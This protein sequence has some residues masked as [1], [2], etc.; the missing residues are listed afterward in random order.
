MSTTTSHA[1]SPVL[2]HHQ[3]Q[4][5]QQLQPTEQ[6]LFSLDFL[7]LAG[8]DS[9]MN[10]GSSHSAGLDMASPQ[11]LSGQQPT[12]SSD[13]GTNSSSHWDGSG[14]TNAIAG[15]SSHASS[16]TAT[17]NTSTD[18]EMGFGTQ[19][20]DGTSVTASA[21]R[22]RQKGSAIERRDSN[23]MEV[24][25]TGL[26]YLSGLPDGHGMLGMGLNGDGIGVGSG[27]GSGNGHD[28]DSLQAALLQQ[29]LQAIHMQSPLGFD[30]SNPQFPLAQMLLSSPASQMVQLGQQISTEA[31]QD[32]RQQQHRQRASLDTGW[33]VNQGPGGMPTPGAS[34]EMVPQ[35]KQDVMSPIQ[36]EI[37]ARAQSEMNGDP[38]MLPL[39]SPA[40]SHS[41][42]ASTFNSPATTTAFSSQ[43]PSGHF[44]INQGGQGI[45]NGNGNATGNKS[46]LE[47]LQEQQRQFQEQL[48]VLQQRQLEMQATAAAVVAASNNSPYISSSGPS[49]GPSRPATTPG[50][51]PTSAGGFF[52]PLTSP[53]LEATSRGHRSHGHH[54]HFSPAFNA[55]QAR[56]PHPLSALSSPALN[57]VGSSG[58]AQQTLSPALGPQTGTD[59]SDPDYL[60]ALVGMLDGPT[61]IGE[62]AQPSY[63][64]PSSIVST[65]TAG[66][67]T[68]LASPA[69]MPTG[70]GP[71]R[72][73][74]PAKS[75]P[76]PML[77]P[78]NHR[79]HQR[80]P[81][82]QTGQ[83]SV[84]T[85]PAVQKFHPNAPAPGMGGLGYLPPSAIDHRHLHTDAS[86]STASTPSP[87][88]L[89][90]I[91]PPPPVPHGTA[92]VKKGVAPMTPASLMNLASSAPTSAP[93]LAPGYGPEST[94]SS[95]NSKRSN[96]GNYTQQG[97]PAPPPPRRGNSS[98]TRN[99]TKRQSAVLPAANG[100]GT[101][102]GTTGKKGA[103]GKLATAASGSGTGS[104]SGK[105]A[106]AIRPHGGVGVRAATK[107]SAA[108]SAPP[109]PENRK[110]SHKAAE[111]KRRDSLK[112]GFDELRLLLPPINVEALD[113]ETGEP[114][115]GSSAPRLLP[116]SSLVPD[117][118]PNRGVSKVALLRFSNE[119]IE[120]LKG[121]VDRRDTYIERLR[122]EVRK[123]RARGGEDPNT[124][125]IGAVPEDG[126]S[127]GEGEGDM[128]SSQ[129]GEDGGSEEDVDV[130]E[131]DWR[132]GEDEEFGPPDTS[133]IDEEASD[134]DENEIENADGNEGVAGEE[135]ADRSLN[136]P[137]G[138]GDEGM[139]VELDEADI[140]KAKGIDGTAH[141]NKKRG[142]RS[143]TGTR[144]ARSKSFSASASAG[145]TNSASGG[146]SKSPALKAT[147]TGGSAK[148]PSLLKSGSSSGNTIT[149]KNR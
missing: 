3:H 129:A 95:G 68:I 86:Q 64:S 78:T 145:T 23:S 120:K 51:T 115:P 67:S 141:N 32:G 116:K 136:G 57:P 121:R 26:D 24:D 16:S 118:N 31:G 17:R 131:Y 106:L 4:Q 9:G 91:M 60:R 104:G 99:A 122:E 84:P 42:S 61:S 8:L 83:Y 89:S 56:T 87:V 14:H 110:T 140:E 43:P 143:S 128:S 54:H 139:D 52:S 27:G 10:A 85:S 125:D 58:G 127:E 134:A 47:Q 147:G 146:T 33:A 109:E 45:G 133:D 72:H 21:S 142:A 98:G 19:P 59:L 149:L 25:Q 62:P 96:E 65:S 88:D 46:P 29:Q 76:S 55:Q 63:H 48:A 73:S 77:K 137:E 12:K 108:L 34:G 15:P 1:A 124:S 18:T 71:H 69:L 28:F 44:N 50:M 37:F 123:L 94:S 92:K 80:V 132:E 138:D 41:T 119:Y 114:I 126:G 11:G 148:R 53:A 103:A 82:G 13:A 22:R 101:A 144:G 117:D 70:T 79:S 130:L 113:A 35:N 74:L 20:Q 2:H 102:A 135:G 93:A 38:N 7:A 111:Q 40:L 112:A 90:Q 100:A 105:R 36:L 81:S 49:S 107:A 39:L 97:V 5:Q 75:R 30:I 6:E 66:H